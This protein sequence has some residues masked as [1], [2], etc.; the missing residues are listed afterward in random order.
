MMEMW[1]LS[2]IDVCDCVERQTM[3]HLMTCADAPTCTWAHLAIPSLYRCRCKTLRE[4]YLTV[5]IMDSTQ[6]PN[7][8]FQ[9]VTFIQVVDH[10]IMH[11][12]AH[13]YIRI[14]KHACTANAHAYHVINMQKR[15][16]DGVIRISPI[17][18]QR[19][20]YACL[21]IPALTPAND[22]IK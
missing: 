5:S 14:H 12:F 21:V 9:N 19:V 13:A 15:R 17:G 3:Y 22:I 16:P 1:K 11:I 6:K 20:C 10:Y 4:V 2:Y 7:S 18:P 8:P